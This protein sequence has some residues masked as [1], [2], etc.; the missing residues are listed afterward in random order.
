MPRP[1]ITAR[2]D[3]LRRIQLDAVL[4]WLEANI[5]GGGGGGGGPASW[6]SITGTLSAQTDLN[7]ALAG[8]ADDAATTSALAGK[9][10]TILAGSAT[11]TVP[12]GAIEARATV[13]AAVSP[14]SRIVLTL[15]TMADADEN[16][17]ELLDVAALAAIPGTGSFVIEAAFLTPT[18]GSVPV[19]WSVI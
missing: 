14:T 2:Q 5:G 16:A 3:P 4:D 18:A 10:D 15:G 1:E 17:A 19:N 11:L 7:N 12:N 8:K 9:Q 13:T 6:G